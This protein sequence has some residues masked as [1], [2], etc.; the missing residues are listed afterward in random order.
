[1]SNYNLKAEVLLIYYLSLELEAP[2]ARVN[3]DHEAQNEQ[4]LSWR[5]LDHHEVSSVCD[6]GPNPKG[7]SNFMSSKVAELDN[8]D[9]KHFGWVNLSWSYINCRTRKPIFLYVCVHCTMYVVHVCALNK[10]V[11]NKSIWNNLK[12]I[13][14]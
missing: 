5:L 1:M 12:F 10:T 2:E 11:W 6:Q 9:I 3:S 4:L 7:E 8:L 14:Q 13:G